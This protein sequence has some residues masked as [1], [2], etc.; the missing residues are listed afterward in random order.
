MN[1][2][3]LGSLA[4]SAASG[5]IRAAQATADTA[6]SL[7]S[8]ARQMVLTRDPRLT[9]LEGV[10]SAFTSATA[11]ADTIHAALAARLTALEQKKPSV[12]A[13]GTGRIAAALLVGGKA[14]IV[15]TLSRTM[16]TDTYRVDIAPTA[17]MALAVKSQTT[18]T[19][20]VTI[21]ATLALAIGATFTVLAI[22]T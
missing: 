22:G 1:R 4:A 8:N 20:T 18:T 11:A 10:A 19:V 12:T 16:P 5:A 15:V 7:A 9:T 14:D 21:S 13:I 17:G 2:G 3:I 6:L